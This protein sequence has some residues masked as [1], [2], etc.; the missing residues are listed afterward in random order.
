MISEYLSRL[1]GIEIYPV[2]S[3]VIFSTLFIVTII[4]VLKLD[5]KYIARMENIPL[6]VTLV[7]K[8]ERII[9]QNNAEIKNE[10]EK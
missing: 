3:L 7:D 1:E 8:S 2:I 6:D 10:T 5:K 4:W 9:F